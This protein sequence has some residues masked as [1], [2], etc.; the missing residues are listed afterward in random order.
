MC[1]FR[2][3]PAFVF[4][5]LFGG[6]V[7]VVPTPA[8]SWCC[9]LPGCTGACTKCGGTCYACCG[10]RSIDTFQ[11]TLLTSNSTLDQSDIQES[12][13]QSVR[14]LDITEASELTR[15]RECIRRSFTLWMLGNPE[16]SMKFASMNFGEPIFQNETLVSQI[17]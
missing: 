1:V 12:L 10:R 5:V 9:Q 2:V 13:P 14:S 4:F 16:D 3:I 6:Q 8:Y 11:S 7:V 15:G 17:K